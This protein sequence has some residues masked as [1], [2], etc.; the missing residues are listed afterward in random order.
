MTTHPRKRLKW[1]VFFAVV[2]VCGIWFAAIRNPKAELPPASE[3]ERTERLDSYPVAADYLHKITEDIGE[4][5]G[6]SENASK[7][8]NRTVSMIENL[9]N[10]FSTVRRIAGPSDWPLIQATIA[11]KKP[12]FPAVWVLSSYDSRPG[13]VGVEANA[14]GMAATLAV[15]GALADTKP[16]T[17]IHFVFFPHA[18]DPESPVLETADT[19]RRI[20]TDAGKPNAILCVE[21]MG[22]GP[23][24][25]L[26]SRDTNAAPLALADGIGA[27]QGAEVICLGDDVDLASLLFQMDLP[28]VRVATRPIV[29]PAESDDK[30]PPVETLA[31]STGAL[32]KLIRRCAG[33]N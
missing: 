25:W 24:L 18:N 2:S 26:S 30:S 5:N 14:T 29:T 33:L 8:L 21:A 7:N 31:A 19:F 32:L 16:E 17:D 27:V 1:L 23:I 9:M 22:A 11:G 28:A 4:R 3:P 6:V 20:C 13:S 15:A 12:K 10:P